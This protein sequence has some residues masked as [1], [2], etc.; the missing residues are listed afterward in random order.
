MNQCKAFSKFGLFIFLSL[1]L[2]I[3]CEDQEASVDSGDKK[4]EQ[5]V[6][7]QFRELSS[8]KSGINFTNQVKETPSKHIGVFDYYYNGGGVAVGDI[9]NDGL[10]DIFFA[11]N[12]TTSALYLN[13]GNLRF[14][15]ITNSA[16][17]TSPRWANGVTM[18][19]INKDGNLDIY[20]CHGGPFGDD[21]S[22]MNELWINNGDLTFTEKSKSYGLNDGSR[23]IQ[24]S[25][26]DFDKD[27]DLDMW[28][29]NHAR[30]R[31]GSQVQEFFKNMDSRVPADEIPKMKNKY[32]ENLGGQFYE[33]SEALGVDDVA[34]GLGLVTADLND[35]GWLDVYVANDYFI[36]DF[37]YINNKK[38]GFE[39]QNKLLTDHQSYYSMGTD[40]ADF[41]NDGML[42]LAVV[43]MTPSDHVRN[44]V[45]MASMNVELSRY[46]TDV[47]KY[48]DQFMFNS[49]YLNRGQGKLSDIA[50]LLGVSMTEW[51]WSP[52]LADFDL[53]GYKDYF[54]SNGFYRDTRNNDYIKKIDDFEAQ[55]GRD[56]TPE[57][58]F[59]KILETPSTPVMN[60]LFKNYGG[61]NFVDVTDSWG[62]KTPTFSAGAAYSDLD[63]D[64]D[65]DIICNNLGSP[66]TILENLNPNN[67]NHLAII[68]KDE[69]NPSSVYHAKVYV[70]T[71]GT[72]QRYDYNFT[73]GYES[74][75]SEKLIIGLGNAEKVE[76]VE[77]EYLSGEFM[78]V[79]NIKINET[80]VITK[81]QYMARV[82]PKEKPRPK[83]LD[84][85]RRINNFNFSHSEIPFDDFEKE[86][87]LPHKYSNM[88]PCVAVG[89][90]NGD[91]LDDFFLGGSSDFP[92]QIILQANQTFVEKSNPAF[93]LDKAY[94]DIGA[95]F[96]DC[97]S[98]GDLDL[99]VASG[100]GGEI[101]NP[102]LLKD[103]LYLNNGDGTFE[104]SVGIIPDV[105]SSTS[106]LVIADFNGDKKDDILVGG[107]NVPG[108]YPLPAQSYL[109]IREGST[110]VDKTNDFFGKDGLPG[111]IT[112]MV[113][114]DLNGDGA[115]ELVVV[116]EWDAPAIY[117]K[118]G[119]S[120]AKTQIK[121]FEKYKGWWQAVNSI[122]VD[123]DGDLDLVFGNLGK[124]NKFQPSSKK[125]LGVLASDFDKNG[126]HDIVLTKP[127]KDRIVPVRGKECST[128]QMP[129]LQEK[130]ESYADFANSSVYEILGEE[131]IEEA[132]EFEV[133][134]F[135]H[136]MAIN[137]NGNF[138]LSELPFETQ[139][140][141]IRA[142]VVG[143]FNGDGNA[144]VFC[145]GNITETEPETTA[146]DAGMGVLLLGDGKGGF[147][148][149]QSFEFTG[150]VCNGNVT[151]M[152]N[153][154][155]GAQQ[156]GII[157]GNNNATVQLL[158]S[159]KT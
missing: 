51:S 9:N 92:G 136:Y 105:K 32:Y 139:L 130:Y 116:S 156:K 45:L 144:D 10:D 40:A 84:I 154:R 41:N 120:F 62:I 85:S 48:P 3:S 60:N 52:L 73:R 2:C 67:H 76:K 23:S 80:N 15:D 118:K 58:M 68:L 97:D 20:I 56:M 91:N 150:S 126:T 134:T 8:S 72:R 70:T 142:M 122:D 19:D 22:L 34:F 109:M 71:D 99:Y 147:T 98:D 123:N 47:M 74:H 110:F 17:L 124:N 65:L 157:V 30:R 14:E 90:L 63:N 125:P 152:E 138:K 59:E 153:I 158:V 28:L 26:A 78:A 5:S 133:T 21:F 155:L 49:F 115:K 29:N 50:H 149:N 101:T 146:Y 38:G 132:S 64:G 82:Q 37:Y 143:D 89:D 86:I 13:K 107:R 24:A 44:K 31:I 112:E 61:Q 108:E 93:I 7:Q 127:Y 119:N 46:L 27:G 36:P 106:A 42:D 53:D 111:M 57:E 79:D 75:V 113:Y 128:E 129:F 137:D 114:E 94:E 135:A 81:G 95:V 141:P 102:E 55:M 121:T 11:G 66:A 6:K 43:D 140:A 12:D 145:A 131:N 117:E 159:T 69:V 1:F 33:K 87:L 77:V 96:F 100:G 35:D 39:Q 83:L 151:D 104:S 16:G 103:R 18:V 88:G 25:F 148:T 54:V 4:E